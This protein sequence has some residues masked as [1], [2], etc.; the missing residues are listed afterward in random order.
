L[1][2]KKITDLTAEAT[3]V[4]AD[5]VE[6]VDDVAGTATSKKA[7][8]ANLSKGLDAGAIPNTPAGAIAAT[9]VQAA[10]D[11]LDTE[12]LGTGAQ[13]AT[14]ATITGL[15]PDTA[16]TQATQASITTAANLTTIGTVTTGGLGTGAVIAAPTMTLGSDADGD[17]YYRSSNVLT[18]LAKGSATEVLTMNAG[19]TA[20]EWAAAGGGGG[21]PRSFTYVIAASDSLDNTGVDA[22]CDGTAD[23][24]EINAGIV[25]VNGAG[26]GTVMLLDGTYNITSTEIAYLS[27][28]TLM[29]QGYGTLLKRTANTHSII[30][31]KG[32][33][34]GDGIIRDI[35]FDGN[36]VSTQY[37]INFDTT[38][39]S[40]D[41]LITNCWF[42]TYGNGINIKSKTSLL[43]NNIFRTAS[44][45][46]STR[47]IKANNECSIVGNSFYI[48]TG[49]SAHSCIS[50]NADQQLITGNLFTCSTTVGC[51]A[52]NLQGYDDITI[53]GNMFQGWGTPI[54]GSTPTNTSITGNCFWLFAEEA[55][56]CTGLID[57]T[58][59]GN[60]FGN[61][62]GSSYS[63]IKA[64]GAFIGS[65]VS[66]NTVDDA[67]VTKAFIEIPAAT[68]IDNVITGNKCDNNSTSFAILTNNNG[69]N[70]IYG[71]VGAS[72]LEE[73][74]R[75][76]M[77]NT[78]GGAFAVGDIVT[79]KAVAAGNEV[80]TSTAQGDDLIF[81]MATEIIADNASGFIQILGK[82]TALKVD[83]TTDIAVGDFIGCFT[84][85]KIGMKA[86]AGDMAIAIALEAYTT[87]DSAGVID[88]ILI[89]PRKI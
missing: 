77:K 26:G 17:V 72:V 48:T 83:G 4:A 39:T 8:L 32:V 59:S 66:G 19:A 51:D 73:Q 49:S 56:D 29:G 88:A 42:K 74:R 81:G 10:I 45:G 75:M 60:T 43:T 65:V 41:F 6:I 58:V 84:T 76:F 85:A 69:Q 67:A 5:L 9:D 57:C 50:P 87:D 78:S 3:P 27:N 15:A 55:I 54:A 68:A 37:L 21:G 25:A 52:I 12:K 36:S 11:E 70:D 80:T 31:D 89:S 40:G 44:P 64:T 14:V 46:S 71:N 38:S 35:R 53:T 30:D 2:N 47:G 18:R 24:V 16:T 22:T 33:A 13:A 86:A 63:I 62:P 61:L 34:I 28:V 1:A 7:T 20:P 23:E 82:T 79:L